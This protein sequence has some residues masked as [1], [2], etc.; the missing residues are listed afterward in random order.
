MNR[1]YT[2]FPE[3]DKEDYLVWK[4]HETATNQIVAETYFEEDAKDYCEFLEYGGAFN[5]F[6][7]SFIIRKTQ[8]SDINSRFEME[9]SE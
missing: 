7:P 6:T 5:G 9:F 4:V 8:L 3:F 1:L 2:F